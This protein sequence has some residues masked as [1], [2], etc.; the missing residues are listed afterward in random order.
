MK[1]H[2]LEIVREK[3][4]WLSLALSGSLWLSLAL[5]GSLWLTLA[6]SVALSLAL[7]LSSTLFQHS[8]IFRVPRHIKKLFSAAIASTLTPQKISAILSKNKKTR[9]LF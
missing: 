9:I 5:S 4:L 6:L 1:M 8:S 7:S 2:E 3:F